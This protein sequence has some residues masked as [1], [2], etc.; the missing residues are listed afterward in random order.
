[1][2]TP[3]TRCLLLLLA[4]FSIGKA[5][6]GDPKA[7][8]KGV[9]LKIRKTGADLKKGIQLIELTTR[10]NEIIT[11][12]NGSLYLLNANVDGA[13]EVVTDVSKEDEFD[14]LPLAATKFDGKMMRL[15][16]LQKTLEEL[17]EKDTS[18]PEQLY[19]TLLSIKVTALDTLTLIKA[20]YESADE[21]TI[22]TFDP[23]P[24]RR[25]MEATEDARSK[26]RTCIGIGWRNG[27]R[28]F[29]IGWGKR[30]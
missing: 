8:V 29:G 7:E 2:S 14:D 19:Q 21:T 16:K 27:R 10:M 30:S 20:I 22:V 15:L 18:T 28:C 26:R 5:Q 25:G 11:A 3:G 23:T 13:K 4:I 17:V 24:T 12:V 1:M 6:D 9:I